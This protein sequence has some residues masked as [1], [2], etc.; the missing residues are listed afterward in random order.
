MHPELGRKDD[1]EPPDLRCGIF[2]SSLMWAGM[3]LNW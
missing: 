1:V 3:I 2:P